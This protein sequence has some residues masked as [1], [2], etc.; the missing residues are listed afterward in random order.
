MSLTSSHDHAEQRPR[1]GGRGRPITRRAAIAAL[2]G[3][4]VLIAG[5]GAAPGPRAGGSGAIK[6]RF[7]AYARCMRGHGVTDFPDPTAVPG[8]GLAFSI[9]GGPGS[10]LNQADP[11]F[12]A[13]GRACRGLAPGARQAATASAPHI[14]AE[15]RWARC[16]RAHGVPSFPDP[17]R[18]GA[19]DSARFDPS[20]P[21]FRTATRACRAVQPHGSVS[22]VPGQP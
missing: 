19:F 15:L 8:G 17:D 10:D 6:A 3:L 9:D 12:A 20:S 11:T 22:A 4:A 21:A 7:V 18:Q 1:G 14:A 5:C 13:A 16:L 2:L